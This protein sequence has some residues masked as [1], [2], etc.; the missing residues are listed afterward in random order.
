MSYSPQLI[1]SQAGDVPPTIP[2]SPSL[3]PCCRCCLKYLRLSL[4][5][6][7]L[8]VLHECLPCCR[9]CLRYMRLSLPALYLHVLHECLEKFLL[10]QRV[11]Q[12]GVV[13]TAITTAL[14]PMYCYLL[15]NM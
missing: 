1:P 14:T 8:Q 15:I 5:A 13:I 4:P 10:A 7:Y 2:P 3:Q 12:P 11:V 9:C 6:L